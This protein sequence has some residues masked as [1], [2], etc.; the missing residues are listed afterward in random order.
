MKKT[1]LF[2]VVMYTVLCFF[3]NPVFAYKPCVTVYGFETKA[4][5]GFWHDAKW[6]VGTGMGRC[7]Q[8]RL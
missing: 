7:F 1:F 8:M 3:S 5:S 2:L 4:S 6:D